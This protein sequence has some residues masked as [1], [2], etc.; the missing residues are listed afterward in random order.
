[1]LQSLQNHPSE[2]Q[3]RFE[4]ADCPFNS[5]WRESKVQLHLVQQ[6]MKP[7]MMVSTER[8]SEPRDVIAPTYM[9]V[10]DSA[11]TAADYTSPDFWMCPSH[12][13][14]AIVR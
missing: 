9:V 13:R 8:A 2:H 1:M 11:S 5:I 6:Y 4:H 12:R 3:Y 14:L 7:V 10:F